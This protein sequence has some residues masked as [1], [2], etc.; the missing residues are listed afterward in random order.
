MEL[1][2]ALPSTQFRVSQS[3]GQFICVAQGLLF[4]GSMLAYDPVSNEEEWI[5]VW[6]M[7]S[8]MSQAEEASAR[9]LSN[10][11]PHNLDKGTRRL[12]WFGKQRSQSSAEES[13][14]KDNVDDNDGTEEGAEETSHEEEAGDEPMDQG[15]EGDSDR[16]SK[17]S[18]STDATLDGSCSPAS[19]QGSTHSLHC[20]SSDAVLVVAAGQTSACPRMQV[21]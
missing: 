13:S 18:G 11:V 7:V 2:P 14:T 19:S 6:G 4:E 1:G 9:E 5:L 20:Y 16:N 17:K 21:T 10:M 12:D 3:G 8:D 15:Y